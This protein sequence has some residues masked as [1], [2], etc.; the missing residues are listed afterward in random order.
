MVA[1]TYPYIHF[2]LKLGLEVASHRPHTASQATLER[3]AMKRVAAAFVFGFVQADCQL[4]P[5]TSPPSLTSQSLLTSSRNTVVVQGMAQ[6][7]KPLAASIS[8]QQTCVS[9]RSATSEAL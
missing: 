3:S 2:W 5:K 6:R 9:P 1:D 4:D 7:L 8:S